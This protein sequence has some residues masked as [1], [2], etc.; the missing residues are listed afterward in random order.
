MR[1]ATDVSGLDGPRATRDWF[2]RPVSERPEQRNTNPFSHLAYPCGLAPGTG[3]SLGIVHDRE[4]KIAAVTLG[5]S[6]I[7]KTLAPPHPREAQAVHRRHASDLQSDLGLKFAPAAQTTGSNSQGVIVIGI[8][9]EG[10]AADLGIKAGDITV[11]VSGNAVHTPHDISNALNEALSRGRQA[12]LMR[13]K[14]G[15]T[16]RF[17]AVPV[18][19]A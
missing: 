8:D 10:R 13:L 4:E 15:N 3:I 17:I 6:P 11:E 14:S 7:A 18:D 9:P 1:N 2:I 16:L 12:V 5:H 19:P